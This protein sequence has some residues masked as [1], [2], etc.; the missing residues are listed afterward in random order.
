M[1]YYSSPSIKKILLVTY[2]QS[3]LMLKFIKQTLNEKIISNT[4]WDSSKIYVLSSH[5]PSS[6]GP[7][8][9]TFVSAFG[10]CFFY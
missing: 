7:Q 4:Q 9:T 8:A 6:L 5:M 1:K 2:T 3:G 10:Y